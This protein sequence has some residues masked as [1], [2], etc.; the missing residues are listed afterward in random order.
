M[1]K[2]AI[3]LITATILLFASVL[4][5]NILYVKKVPQS[6]LS[7]N[8]STANAI[9]P[10]TSTQS[11]LSVQR[12]TA[13]NAADLIQTGPDAIGGIG[14]WVLT[15]GTICAVITDVPH[16]NEFSSKGGVLTDLGFC[17][18]KDD[19]FT[20]MQDILDADRKRPMDITRIESEVDANSASIIT[21][22][23]RDAVEVQTRYRLRNTDKT[24]LSISKKVSLLDSEKSTFNLYTTF[25]FNYHSMQPF[26]YSTKNSKHTRGFNNVDFVSRGSSAIPDAA[27]A[28]DVLILPGPHDAEDGVSYGWQLLSAIRRTGDEA[29]YLPS[30]I[31]SDE[32]MSV[33]AILPK[34]F[35]L[36][37]GS[38][39]GFIQLPQI[40]LLNLSK[41][42]S[43][44]T[45]ELIYV[46]QS[47]DV[48]S[49][50][51]QILADAPLVSGT[52]KD[53]KTALHIKHSDGRPF[54]F[55]RP[56]NDGR[57]EFRAKPGDYEITHRGSAGRVVKQSLS[58]DTEDM[59]LG[60]LELPAAT[61]LTLPRNEAMRLIFVGRDG[62]ENPDFN[63][64]LTDFTVHDG[65]TDVPA[66]KISQ[67]FLAGIDS[68]LSQ[69]E[70]A[71]GDYTVY[72]T[73][74]PEY[75][76]SKKDI[77]VIAGQENRLDIAIPVHQVKTPGYIA[78][79][80]HVHSGGGFDNVFST[81]ERVRSFVAEHGEVMV[82][83]EHDVPLNFSPQIVNMGVSDKITSIDGVEMTG[84]M[85]S[86]HNPHTVGHV[87]FFPVSPKPHEYRKGMPNHEHSRLRD[88]LHGFRHEH[89]EVVAQ[90]NHARQHLY[91]SS[92]LPEDYEELIDNGGY[93]NHMGIAGHPYNPEK[94][95]QSFPNNSLIER[96]PAT[97]TR[98]IDI[99]AM[100]II[101]PSKNHPQDRIIAMRKDWMSFL[102][103]GLRITGTANSDSH[104]ANEQVS[105]P[106]NM[107]A[108]DS[109][110][111]SDS[112]VNFNQDE[113]ITSLKSGNAYGTTGP[114]L[115]LSLSGKSMGETLQ[116]DKAT[117]QLKVTSADWIPVDEIKVQINGT[118][119]VTLTL[120]ETNTYE[121]ELEFEKDSFVTVEVSGKE[122]ADYKT[123]YPVLFPYAFSNPIYVDYNS[124]G[125]WAPPGL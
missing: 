82:S 19:H 76:L 63:L 84:T 6:V 69:V 29:I 51:N 53:P 65:E 94:S 78:G 106:R 118:D 88:M 83:S 42:D 50:T 41:G 36:G 70:I 14:D 67:V 80:L 103:Q 107:V 26:I 115:E 77:T 90:L 113:F 31:L 30:F 22:A 123:I 55:V 40:P 122:T 37:D 27:V 8:L 89:G 44:E 71:P 17:G 7:S 119:H 86:E 2:L 97:G 108:M 58:L 34:H 23:Q 59:D 92:D 35:Y 124:D 81:Q 39:L 56:Q 57:F 16:E 79:D 91:L 12:I 4:L 52:V 110:L 18:R 48:A 105:V 111:G 45:E 38:N 101:N 99:D 68:D 66:K 21:Y 74:G 100:E 95:L 24:Q 75:S 10:D 96:D 20:T 54:T 33:R 3:A 11:T 120:N 25:W 9:K 102:N 116:A 104:H 87:N 5:N 114:M 64:A 62:T 32:E 46:G 112:V 125:E 93:L 73:R 61:T 49:I 98:D 60:V 47:S 109:E 15:N 117:L 72:A 121:V 85:P 43:L 13:E 1:K 28:A